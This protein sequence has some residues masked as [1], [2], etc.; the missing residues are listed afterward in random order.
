MHLHLKSKHDR[1]ARRVEITPEGSQRQMDWFPSCHSK[2]FHTCHIHPFT[3]IHVVVASHDSS[4]LTIH[5]HI[6]TPMTR[7]Q[8]QL[9]VQYRAHRFRQVVCV[10]PGGDRTHD[11]LT[12]RRPGRGQSAAVGMNVGAAV[13]SRSAA[14]Q[15]SCSLYFTYY[16]RLDLVE[17]KKHKRASQSQFTT[18]FCYLY[19]RI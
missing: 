2:H 11:L 6:L 10:K 5:T 1:S 8:R 4:A 3:P 7:R 16:I 18:Y 19:I 14:A 15:D 13:C 17:Q 9:R 12:H